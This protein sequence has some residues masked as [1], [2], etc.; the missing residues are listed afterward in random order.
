MRLLLD[1][2]IAIWW[3]A[4]NKN[5]K[6]E[7]RRQINDAHCVLSVVTLWEVAIKFSLGKLDLSPQRVRDYY[8]I[9][10]VPILSVNEHHAIACASI[11]P[12]HGDPFDRML[13]AVAQSE[14][15]PLMTADK[16]LRRFAEGMS[17]IAIIAA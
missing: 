13:L 7:A 8:A 5:L 2:Q 10:G 6:A 1:T 16:P 14:R 4:N 12:G 3:L 17:G 9:A 15:M 11:P